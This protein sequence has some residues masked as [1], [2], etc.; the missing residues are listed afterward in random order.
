MELVKRLD[1]DA[2]K[3]GKDMDDVAAT[4]VVDAGDLSYN[5]DD[6]DEN[7]PLEGAKRRY[8]KTQAQLKPLPLDMV[9][10]SFEMWKKYASL[11]ENW[12]YLDP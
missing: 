7:G 10:L 12:D 5:N 9:S 11:G 4:T 2:Q 1:F 3:L 8:A 6:G